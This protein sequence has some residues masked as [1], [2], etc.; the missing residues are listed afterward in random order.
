MRTFKRVFGID[1]G[2]AVLDGF[3]SVTAKSFQIPN[4]E[5]SISEWIGQVDPENDLVVFEPTGSYSD[6]LLHL[7]CAACIP[8]CL[9]S[10]SQSH[11]FAMAQ[12]IISKNDRQAARTLALMGQCLELPLFNRQEDTMYKRKQLLLGI[13]A[14][15]KQRQMLINQLHAL[16]FQKLFAPT[17]RTALEETLVTVEG[18]ISQLEGEL[19]GLDDEEHA[20]QLALI[21]SV[22]GIGKKTA[23]LL[24]A[25][26][27]GLQNFQRGQQ[28]SKFIGIVPSSHFSGTS[29]KIRGRITKKG[30]K[31]L[32]ASLYMAARSAKRFNMACKELYD[33][34]RARGKPHKQVMVAI[35]NK[36]IKQAYGVVSSKL[37]FDN[38]FYLKFQKT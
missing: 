4:T 6:R 21:T 30:N 38:Q 20:A 17:V 27:G 3:D 9:V 19:D 31:A 13:N 32:R 34:L 26:T 5:K 2:S 35:M 24:L 15:K 12:G 10:P 37:R 23:N 29:V 22:V 28:V 25:A 33:R 36:L 7:L 1:V 11:G 8:L 14:L 16:S 18:N